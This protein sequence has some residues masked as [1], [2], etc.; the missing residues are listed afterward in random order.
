M[1]SQGFKDKELFE[2]CSSPSPSGASCPPTPPE[3]LVS[4][5]SPPPFPNCRAK[6]LGTD[7]LH[8]ALL[9]TRLPPPS[10]TLRAKVV[11]KDPPTPPRARLRA[12]LTPIT[13]ALIRE[14]Q[15]CHASA[16]INEV[17]GEHARYWFALVN[18]QRNPLQTWGSGVRVNPPPLITPPVV[19]A[20]RIGWVISG[21]GGL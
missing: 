1:S 12:P 4:P 6:A 10:R 2:L 19:V 14:N 5:V 18:P 11:P 8:E 20:L 9:F 21:G 15:G 13:L 7:A 16:F 3:S 17:Y